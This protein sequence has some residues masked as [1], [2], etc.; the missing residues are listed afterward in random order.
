[1]P[2]CEPM[3]KP[4]GIVE[5]ALGVLA[6]ETTREAAPPAAPPG[7]SFLGGASGTA[8]IEDLKRQAS[9]WIDRVLEIVS[10][11]AAGAGGAAR[12]GSAVVPSNAADRNGWGPPAA[13]L[14]RPALDRALTLAPPSA[15]RPGAVA[16]LP[17]RLANDDAIAALLSFAATELIGESGHRIPASSVSF[18]P[19][20]P[21]IPPGENTSV[22]IEIAVPPGTPPGQYAGVIQIIGQAGARKLISIEV[23]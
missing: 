16:N 17:M 20:G 23:R 6:R 21:L 14:P 19:P 3:S 8:A 22:A 10:A 18:S 1:M 7:E 2:T 13:A 4:S 12:P 15:V 9:Q 5:R 11:S